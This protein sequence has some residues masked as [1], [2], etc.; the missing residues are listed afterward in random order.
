MRRPK[1]TYVTW[2]NAVIYTNQA[3]SLNFNCLLEL[4]EIRLLHYGPSFLHSL[5]LL[6]FGLI[7][8]HCYFTRL[9]LFIRYT[10]LS[11]RF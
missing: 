10:Y 3:P 4:T 7:I 1:L 11:S 6:N 8:A 2:H 9:L 5:N